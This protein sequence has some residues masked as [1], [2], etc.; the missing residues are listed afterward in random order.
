M[1]IL[2]L[3]H[4]WFKLMRSA[5]SDFLAPPLIYD[6]L[7]EKKMLHLVPLVIF[8]QIY[9]E[10]DMRVDGLLIGVEMDME[11]S[12]NHWMAWNMVNLLAAEFFLSI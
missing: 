6:A 3:G 4:L 1:V 5:C 9:R 10:H 11:L 8:K 2:M 7:A 12:S